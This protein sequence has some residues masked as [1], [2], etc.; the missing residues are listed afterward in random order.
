MAAKPAPSADSCT[1][2][3]SRSRRPLRKLM[4][5]LSYIESIWNF[6]LYSL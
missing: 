5:T 2:C 6:V 4:D 1:I 3:S